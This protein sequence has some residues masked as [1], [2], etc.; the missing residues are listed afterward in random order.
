MYLTYGIVPSIEYPLQ[1]VPVINA[2]IYDRIP[3]N[4]SLNV[5][6]MYIYED[7]GK[8]NKWGIYG[9]FSNLDCYSEEKDGN[10]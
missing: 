7:V 6:Y 5:L 9:R 4:T 3:I 1:C 8:V 2:T 10:G